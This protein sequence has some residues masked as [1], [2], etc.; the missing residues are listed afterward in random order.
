MTE[1]SSAI[2]A[3]RSRVCR[4]LAVSLLLCVAPLVVAQEN[5][6]LVRLLH[7]ARDFRVR[8]RAAFVLGNSGQPQSAASLEQA[9]S[10]PHPAVRAA[11]A[12]ALGNVGTPQSL[13]ALRRAEHDREEVVREQAARAIAQIEATHASQPPTRIPARAGSGAAAQPSSAPAVTF[14]GKRYV[15]VVGTMANRSEHQDPSAAQVL[16][17][18]ILATLRESGDVLA[19]SS[20]E[21]VTAPHAKQIR[22]RALP[23]LRL[24]GNLVRVTRRDGA[25]EV[26]V[27]CEV[28]IMI[29]DERQRAVRGA[30]SGAASRAEQPSSRRDEQDRR[31]VE[32]ALIRA[33][34]S[35]L[36]N[37]GTAFA[38][39]SAYG[40]SSAAEAEEP[41]PRLARNR[42]KRS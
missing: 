8:V 27:R 18:E 25:G 3:P 9:L 30:V 17:R 34:R 16:S 10:D 26:S 14:D 6:P 12:T 29:L 24:E 2:T 39:A 11:A 35:A 4:W 5:A 41:E 1:R 31:L 13:A 20:S 23:L 40:A 15:V 42:R 7:D 32:Q 19:F 28:S 21:E 22:E 36:S 38:A 37:I 33:V